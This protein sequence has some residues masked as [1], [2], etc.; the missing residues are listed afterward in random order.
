MPPLFFAAHAFTPMFLPP[1]IDHHQ[2]SPPSRRMTIRLPFYLRDAGSPPF[3]CREY[4]AT[5]ERR[6]AATPPSF[7]GGESFSAYSFPR[8]ARYAIFSSSF[9]RLPPAFRRG[10]RRLPTFTQPSPTARRRC[11]SCRHAFFRVFISSSDRP[12]ASMPRSMP[13]PRGLDR[14]AEEV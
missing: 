11:P 5:P 10:R 6:S 14:H 8:D 3:V 12:I 7:H 9:R 13:P 2:L 1:L 4:G